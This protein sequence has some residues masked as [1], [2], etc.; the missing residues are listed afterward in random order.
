MQKVSSPK[1]DNQECVYV[2]HAKKAF[3]QHSGHTRVRHTAQIHMHIAKCLPISKYKSNAKI[4]MHLKQTTYSRLTLRLSHRV[5]HFGEQ[6]I[7][8]QFGLVH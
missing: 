8:G 6:R 5:Q 4:I 7:L 1:R 2:I 3:A